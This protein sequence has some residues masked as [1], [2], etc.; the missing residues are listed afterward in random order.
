MTDDTNCDV[1]QFLLDQIDTV[2]HLE[3]LLLLWNSRPK[4]WTRED[5]EKAL[6]V[7]EDAA[8]QV[9]DDLVQRGL[10]VAVP[11]VSETYYYEPAPHRDQLMACVDLTYRR[12]LIRISRLIHSKPSA[13]VL[14]F[15]R[16]FRLKKERE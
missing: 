2:P 13:A 6:F 15:A 14:E 5:M 8:K 7:G 10:I 4:L 9:L 1:D 11:G 16:A 3:A 12:E